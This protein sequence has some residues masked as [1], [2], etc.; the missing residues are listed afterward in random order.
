M[1]HDIFD[2][3]LVVR[4]AIPF[5]VPLFFARGYSDT[6]WKSPDLVTQRN[7]RQFSIF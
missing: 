7:Q 3:F 2:E 1:V 5:I 6:L 4:V